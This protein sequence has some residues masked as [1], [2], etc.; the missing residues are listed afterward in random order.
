MHIHTTESHTIVVSVLAF[1][2]T[3]QLALGGVEDGMSEVEQAVKL[4][5]STRV[6]NERTYIKQPKLGWGNVVRRLYHRTSY[7]Y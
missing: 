4:Q 2:P 6:C 3:T 1:T 5:P 7:D